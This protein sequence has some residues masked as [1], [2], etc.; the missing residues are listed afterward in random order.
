[1]NIIIVPQGVWT[2]ILTVSLSYN[3]TII[4]EVPDSTQLKSV[5]AWVGDTAPTLLEDA[6]VVVDLRN[7]KFTTNVLYN[8]TI[9][10]SVWLY[11]V[12]D[13]TKVVI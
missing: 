11:S 7:R 1:M 9:A 3:I 6:V 4:D 13:D 10:A 8:N 12:Y 2:E 5:Y